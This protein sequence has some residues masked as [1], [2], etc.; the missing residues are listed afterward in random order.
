ML[1]NVRLLQ[2][3]FILLII[4]Y[5]LPFHTLNFNNVQ[6]EDLWF[7]IMFDSTNKSYGN[8]TVYVGTKRFDDVIW[9]FSNNVNRSGYLTFSFIGNKYF[10]LEGFYPDTVYVSSQGKNA[11]KVVILMSDS[12]PI[13]KY[14]L[15]IVCSDGTS[16]FYF[17]FYV[18]VVKSPYT[19]TTYTIPTVT[20]TII[21]TQTTVSPITLT[22]TSYITITEVKIVN[23]TVPYIVNQTKTETR[24]LTNTVTET[25]TETRTETLTAKET[26]ITTLVE[27]K[28]VGFSG[29]E[30]LPITVSGTVLSAACLLIVLSYIKFRRHT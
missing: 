11:T 9:L 17:P 13:G 15:T 25:K 2:I 18:N 8:H 1:K 12:T 21:V 20:K 3:G 4:L 27:T 26:Y 30:M 6:A 19:T 29:P 24:T 14:N 7:T 28:E 22:T 5:S 16:K 23:V 10:S